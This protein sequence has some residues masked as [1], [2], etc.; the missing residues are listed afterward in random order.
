[1]S[2]NI[3][4]E[5]ML[6]FGVK[7]LNESVK[8]KIKTLIEQEVSGSAAPG[9]IE[10]GKGEEPYLPQSTDKH[11]VNWTNSFKFKLT[12]KKPYGSKDTAGFENLL[13]Q[14]NEKYAAIENKLSSAYPDIYPLLI[15]NFSGNPSAEIWYTKLNEATRKSMLA[16]LKEYVDQKKE[17]QGIFGRIFKSGDPELVTV[18]IAKGKLTSVKTP[19]PP[20]ITVPISLINVDKSG[21]DIFIDNKSDLT[22]TIKSIIDAQI[23]NVKSEVEKV[24]AEMQNPNLVIKLKLN[25]LSIA[26]SSSRFRNT[27]E[28]SNMTWEQLSRAR[29][30]NVTDYL[31]AQLKA[32]GV[33]VSAAE[34]TVGGGT[35]GDGTT[36]PNPGKDPKGNDYAISV[37][38]TYNNVYNTKQ[39]IE[40]RNEYGEP[41][42]T[43][44]EYNKYKF[45]LLS[46]DIS[47]DVVEPVFDDP[48]VT[49]FRNYSLEIRVK[50]TRIVK[51]KH[52]D[53]ERRKPYGIQK[54]EDVVNKVSLKC[55]FTGAGAGGGG[56]N[57]SKNYKTVNIQTSTRSR[58]K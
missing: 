45:V 42:A 52:G 47:G 11:I 35:N 43:K 4:A 10:V 8:D 30:K 23:E 54:H 2:K 20:P 39:A 25:S 22:D 50:S 38:G 57:P 58:K 12:P 7:N 15:R 19:P 31:Y 46:A 44:E 13:K 56:K 21:G 9:G 27:E 26:S 17:D 34:V 37:D 6:R 33:D 40:R 48:K 53:I 29:S 3:L 55:S 49:Y 14:T 1:M 16:K 51:V 24:K 32:I 5:N 36:G 18:T 28:A 41:L